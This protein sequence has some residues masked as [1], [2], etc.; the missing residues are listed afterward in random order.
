VNLLPLQPPAAAARTCST[1][2]WCTKPHHRLMSSIAGPVHLMISVRLTTV[3]QAVLHMPETCAA[4]AIGCT[5]Q[6]MARM[7][8]ERIWWPRHVGA[9][10]NCITV[11]PV[12]DAVDGHHAA[13]V[14]GELGHVVHLLLMRW[15]AVHGCEDRLKLSRLSCFPVNDRA[16]RGESPKCTCWCL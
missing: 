14:D 10:C 7:S 13:A 5:Q 16:E 1:V 8:T 15:A 4:Q 6:E 2:A 9:C 3:Q 12:L 11:A